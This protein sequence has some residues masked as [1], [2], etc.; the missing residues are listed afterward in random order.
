MKQA[1]KIKKIFI[2]FLKR[3]GAYHKFITNTASI[4]GASLRIKH[5]DNNSTFNDIINN[6]I[7]N[8]NGRNII[9][10]SFYWSETPEG[11]EFW[12]ILDRKWRN[13]VFKI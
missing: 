5:F 3:E 10:Y 2:R 1:D 13:I 9:F 4:C 11:C 8:G 12:R 6:D 7:K